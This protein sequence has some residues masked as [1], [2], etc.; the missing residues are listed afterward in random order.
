MDISISSNF[1]RFLFDL[2]GCDAAK[3]SEK[4]SELVALKSFSVS[5]DELAAAR[6]QFAAIRVDEKQTLNTIRGVF[7][8]HNYILCPHSAVGFCA[9]E[10]FRSQPEFNGE[11]IVVLATAHMGKFVEGVTSSLGS[12]DDV[13]IEALQSCIPT[14]LRALAELGSQGLQRR[15]DVANDAEAVKAYIRQN[16]K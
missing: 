11:E 6:A 14:E 5:S 3:T 13:M 10:Q 12:E 2:W 16:L 8:S 15:V 9:A 1:E 7:A 4:F